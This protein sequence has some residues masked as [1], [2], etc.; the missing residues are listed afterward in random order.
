MNPSYTN[1]TISSSN[2]EKGKQPAS[3]TNYPTHNN[4]HST[5]FFN[6]NTSHQDGV[7]P[8]FSTP[9]NKMNPSYTSP[10]ISSSKKEKGKK[11]KFDPEN[12]STTTKIGLWLMGTS[13]KK[14]DKVQ[15]KQREKE[16]RE[17]WE[18]EGR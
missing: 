12:V 13:V 16:E 5:S 10:T 9:T 17:R 2:K 7:G 3:A 15:E 11:I 1:P 18:K 6:P 8:T 14:M 4:S